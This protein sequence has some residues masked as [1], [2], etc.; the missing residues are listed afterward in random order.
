[1]P[2]SIPKDKSCQCV[3]SSLYKKVP[4]CAAV[5]EASVGLHGNPEAVPS[6]T[7]VTKAPEALQEDEVGSTDP[8]ATLQVG[9]MSRWGQNKGKK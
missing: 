8:S 5:S 7:A 2:K 4:G 6:E 3:Y 9:R 1:M